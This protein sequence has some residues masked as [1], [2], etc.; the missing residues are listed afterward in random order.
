MTADEEFIRYL[1]HL[2]SARTN[3]PLHQLAENTDAILEGLV[4]ARGYNLVGENGNEVIGVDY[5]AANPANQYKLKQAGDFIIKF[6][7][8]F[9]DGAGTVSSGAKLT[10]AATNGLATL[11]D[12]DWVTCVVDRAT[13]GA[14]V[15]LVLHTS[16]ANYITALRAD[17]PAALDTY[18]LFYARD[19]KIFVFGFNQ[20]LSLGESLREG[21][22]VYA[23][24][25]YLDKAAQNRTLI[26]TSGSG[27]SGPTEFA[28]D[29]STGKLTWDGPWQVRSLL[30]TKNNLADAFIMTVAA[31]ATGVTLSNPGDG[32]YITMDRSGSLSTA[33]ASV[34]TAA[35]GV[36]E[37]DGDIFTF[38]VRGEDGRCY[39]WNGTVIESGSAV[40]LGGAAPEGVKWYLSGNYTGAASMSLTTAS[41]VTLLGSST[42]PAEY[43]TGGHN[44]LVYINGQLAKGGVYADNAAAL[45]AGA[46][47]REIDAGGGT[48]TSITWQEDTTGASTPGGVPMYRPVA[49]DFIEIFLPSGATGAAGRWQTM[50]SLALHPYDTPHSGTTDTANT[51]TATGPASVSHTVAQ[52]AAAGANWYGL[53][54][55]QTESRSWAIE[56][57]IDDGSTNAAT[58]YSQHDGTFDIS[59]LSGVLASATYDSVAGT[60]TITPSSGI[61]RRITTVKYWHWRIGTAG[62]STTGPASGAY[63]LSLPIAGT[64]GIHVHAYHSDHTPTDKTTQLIGVGYPQVDVD[65]LRAVAGTQGLRVYTDDHGGT[66]ADGDTVYIAAGGS[67]LLPNDNSFSASPDTS[68]D[69]HVLSPSATCAKGAGGPTA[70]AITTWIAGT[71][72]AGDWL[73][74]YVKKTAAPTSFYSTFNTAA[75]TNNI[76]ASLNGPEYSATHR[77]MIRPGSPTDEEVPIACFLVK[78]AS[79]VVSPQSF[80]YDTG[81]LSIGDIGNHTQIFENANIASSTHVLAKGAAAAALSGDYTGYGNG[82]PADTPMLPPDNTSPNAIPTY[83]KAVTLTLDCTPAGTST[84]YL[85]VQFKTNSYSGAGVVTRFSASVGSGVLQRRQVRVPLPISANADAYKLELVAV[86]SGST[87]FGLAVYVSGLEFY[88]GFMGDL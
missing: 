85:E 74:I 44:I 15:T 29:S 71:P 66:T 60:V 25:L 7:G 64:N 16:T 86:K 17:P 19:D 43:T 6:P 41:G 76:T 42:D 54:D 61:V 84:D 70:E 81:V 39:L 4:S 83:V 55:H 12:D 69:Y 51:A 21:G 2:E 14:T 50:E 47:Y 73:W 48:G 10:A 57:S 11:S 77:M 65:M 26:M 1:E 20:W 22:R 56:L 52:V 78:G 53:A 67:I 28:W 75:N 5:D 36:A 33:T 82:T 46:R 87:N 68:Y 8:L 30:H 80:D 88:R 9:G 13:T 62:Y 24:Q 72:E 35:S 63:S 37:D 79:T 45:A 32:A 40:A 49:A 38:A 3:R 34:A 18:P 31:N 23:S 59:G 58:I 27:A